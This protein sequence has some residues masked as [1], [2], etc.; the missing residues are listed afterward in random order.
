MLITLHMRTVKVNTPNTKSVMGTELVWIGNTGK[1]GTP[2]T[3]T[4]T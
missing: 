3:T 2:M 4:D 1:R